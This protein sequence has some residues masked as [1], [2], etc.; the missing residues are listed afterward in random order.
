MIHGQRLAGPL[1]QPAG[2]SV[3]ISSEWM[4]WT[5]EDDVLTVLQL[6]VQ[7][8]DVSMFGFR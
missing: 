7:D 1:Y 4:A 8:Q 3:T 2:A 6:E 5:T